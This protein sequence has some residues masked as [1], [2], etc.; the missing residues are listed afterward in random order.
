MKLSVMYLVNCEY[1]EKSLKISLAQKIL[2]KMREGS[3]NTVNEKHGFKDGQL[4]I[5]NSEFSRSRY[6]ARDTT[7]DIA[8]RT[9]LSE[10][11]VKILFQNRRTRKNK[12]RRAKE[13][14]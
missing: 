3:V 1:D 10:H 8:K 13:R 14:G 9:G 11:Q 4:E 2:R 7:L 12:R 6:I 5:L